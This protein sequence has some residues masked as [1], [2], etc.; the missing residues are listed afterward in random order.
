MRLRMA[1]ALVADKELIGMTETQIV[2][3]LGRSEMPPKQFGEHAL[4]Y[5]LC[6]EWIDDVWLVILLSEA[7]VCFQAEIRKS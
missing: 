4:A 1:R 7:G 3:K 5:H 2:A 6:I